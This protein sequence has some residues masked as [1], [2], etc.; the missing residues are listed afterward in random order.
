M[1]SF[2]DST[3]IETI[4]GPKDK[5]HI[6]YPNKDLKNSDT[7]CVLEHYEHLSLHEHIR[8][9]DIAEKDTDRKHMKTQG[10]EAEHTEFE[11]K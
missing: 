3:L 8:I 7:E 4:Y 2:I 1:S 11:I 9:E 5:I 10:L 6:A